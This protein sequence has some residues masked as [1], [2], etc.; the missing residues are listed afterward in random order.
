MHAVLINQAAEK[1]W[2]RSHQ[3]RG[4]NCGCLR[5]AWSA[6]PR[7][8]PLMDAEAGRNVRAP[9]CRHQWSAPALEPIACQHGIL[10]AAFTSANGAARC[11]YAMLASSLLFTV[12]GNGG[13]RL[14]AS[15]PL[16]RTSRSSLVRDKHCLGPTMR[17]AH[18]HQRCPMDV[19]SAKLSL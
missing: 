16:Q 12:H 9:R 11:H 1:R 10:L 7:L 19:R 5:G 8:T 6:V 18:W 15:G 13:E 14:R 4:R 3:A 2:K 17:P